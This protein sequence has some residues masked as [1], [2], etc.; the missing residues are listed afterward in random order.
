MPAIAD[1]DDHRDGFRAGWLDAGLGYT[2]TLSRV[3]GGSYSDG[4]NAGQTMRGN[5]VE[6]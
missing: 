5:Y 4:Y 6:S 3:V 1:L 2:S